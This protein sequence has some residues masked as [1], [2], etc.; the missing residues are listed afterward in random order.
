[1][2]LAPFLALA[3][4]APSAPP[5]SPTADHEAIRIE[6]SAGDPA[7]TLTPAPLERL[8][9]AT[10]LADERVRSA[11]DPDD[12]RDALVLAVSGRHAAYLRTGEVVHLCRLIATTDHVLAGDGISPD[13]AAEAAYFRQGARDLLGAKPCEVPPAPPVTP[14]PVAPTPVAPTPVASPGPSTVAPPVATVA[15]VLPLEPSPRRPSPRPFRVAGTVSLGAGTVLL[16]V[17]TAG[18]VLHTRSIDRFDARAAGVSPGQ[19]IDPVTWAAMR[20]DLDRARSNAT[21]RS[22]QVSLPRSPSGSVRRC[23]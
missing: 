22:G 18:V 9:A 15:P 8:L 19:P 21:W 1:M 23:W 7:L 14:A 10:E 16:G 5:L 13:L 6:I 12:A 4:A 20:D 2:V 11:K 3:L 17:M